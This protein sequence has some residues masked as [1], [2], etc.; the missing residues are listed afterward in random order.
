MTRHMTRIVRYLLRQ[1]YENLQDLTEPYQNIVLFTYDFCLKVAQ[2]YYCVPPRT[3][4]T[5]RVL[6]MINN[7]AGLGY[8]PARVS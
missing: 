6:L 1:L 3:E 4:Y 8:P 5:G 7:T 2:W